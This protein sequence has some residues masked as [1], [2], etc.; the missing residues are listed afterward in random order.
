MCP[1]ARL[2]GYA[3]DVLDTEKAKDVSDCV[4]MRVP[5]RLEQDLAMLSDQTNCRFMMTSI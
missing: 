3:L 1:D 5:H 4:G 2:D